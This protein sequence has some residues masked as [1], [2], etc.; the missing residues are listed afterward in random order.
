MINIFTKDLT[1]FLHCSYYYDVNFSVIFI[2]YKM[3]KKDFL[4]S[5]TCSLFG[6][7]MDDFWIDIVSQVYFGSFYFT[8]F[9]FVQVI[10]KPLRILL[11][12]RPF[13]PS[14]SFTCFRGVP[15]LRTPHTID[16][17]RLESFL[18][19]H[20]V[21]TIYSSFHVAVWTVLNMIEQKLI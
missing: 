5:I 1:Y 4:K 14:F 7:R 18:K 9:Q 19:V 8:D 16:H 21:I 12:W 15:S 2:F 11:W 17:N 10:P 3:G 6:L 20:S 13:F